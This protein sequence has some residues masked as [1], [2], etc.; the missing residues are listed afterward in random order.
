MEQEADNHLTDADVDA[1]VDTDAAGT[2]G[3]VKAV[4]EMETRKLP[5]L[6]AVGEDR[7]EVLN[8]VVN[9][10]VE[11]TPSLLDGKADLRRGW[12]TAIE[13]PAALKGVELRDDNPDA[14]PIDLG[15]L[16]RRVQEKLEHTH[17]GVTR[18][19]VVVALGDCVIPH[20]N[21]GFVEL[22]GHLLLLSCRFSGTTCFDSASFSGYTLF[23]SVLFDGNAFFGSASFR[24]DADFKSA[25]FREGAYFGSASFGG[26]ASFPSA[27]FVGHAFFES[28]SFDGNASF[29]FV[30]FDESTFF[31]SASFSG[32]AN[33]EFASFVGDANFLSVSF[34]G[35]TSFESA[36]FGGDANFAHAD[37][38]RSR[39]SSNP[40]PLR[41]DSRGRRWRLWLTDWLNWKRVRATGELTALTRVSYLALAVVPVLAGLWHP[42]RAWIVSFNDGLDTTRAQLLALTDKLPPGD[43]TNEIGS[44]ID[45]LTNTA[46]PDTMP[47]SW[48]LAFSA[49]FA[50]A[51]GRLIYQLTCPE[52][53]RQQS[54]EKMVE[55]ANALN[56]LDAGLD[57][58]GIT[59][60][61]LRQ[62]VDY[63]HDAAQAMP[64][65]HSAWFVRRERRTVWIPNHV[66]EHFENAM[67]DEPRPD[68]APEDW[69]PKKKIRVSDQEVDAEDRKRI[70]IEEG[71]KARYALETF[72]ARPWAWLA[73]GLYILA[74]WFTLIIVLRQLR[75]IALASLPDSG[76]IHRFFESD[77]L[78][79]GMGWYAFWVGVSIIVIATVVGTVL[80]FEP[81]GQWIEKLL[82]KWGNCLVSRCHKVW[83]WIR[84][85]KLPGN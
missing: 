13:H 37:F 78:W 15:D 73:G 4:T 24:E 64:H 67:V 35:V 60:E 25:S 79:E 22:A 31:E 36:S 71:Q 10:W 16:M 68:D 1:H 26:D 85:D 39:I 11:K 30:S 77:F 43:A 14:E 3:S 6:V 56:R 46:L 32:D 29:R 9:D 80:V 84:P 63:L 38:R 83:R 34:G 47:L 61:R 58:G 33:F 62:A 52:L 44:V 57:G 51:V 70:A 27:S 53:V 50:V 12:V 42:V 20:C 7:E 40:I 19:L 66:D 23:Q 74:G 45:H 48:L 75:A 28:V 5:P 21:A 69:E 41:R 59:A 18:P 49:A 76:W 82:E 54:Q 81:V 55:Q 72:R 65:R 2:T 8:R 17:P